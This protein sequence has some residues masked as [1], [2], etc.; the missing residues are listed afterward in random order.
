MNVNTYL[1]EELEFIEIKNDL[2]LR[3]IFCDLGASIFNIY[4]NNELLTRNVK[5]IKDYKL[6]NCYYGKTIGRTSNRLCGPNIFIGSKKYYI[7]PNEGNNILHGG[8]EGLSTKRFSYDIN[9]QDEYVR[10]SFKYLSKH[11]EGG[12]PGNV[13][14]KVDYFVYRLSN[15]V[16]IYY[17]A[18]CDEDTILSLTN[19]TYFTL[20]E[21]DISNLELF[22]R[23]KHYLDVDKSTLLPKTISIIN[24]TMD[25]TRYKQIIKDINDE[26][27]KGKMLNGYDHFWYFDNNNINKVNVSIRNNKYQLNIYSDFEGTQIYTSN[28]RNSFKLDDNSS[29]IRDSV[30]IEPSDSFLQQNILLKDHQYKRKIIYQFNEIKTDKK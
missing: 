1:K 22:V 27:L 29:G 3:V 7:K 28:F 26:S 8:S 6:P 20:G 14:I 19:H 18:S 17:D 4:F 12:Y 16:A 10:V 15:C 21:N 24:K 5:N 11:L 2:N 30:A 23:G 25:F 9:I 13:L